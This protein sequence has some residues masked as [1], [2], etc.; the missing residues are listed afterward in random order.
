[1]ANPIAKLE[2]LEKEFEKESHTVGKGSIDVQPSVA[3]SKPQK[4]CT[5]ADQL[6]K[7]RERKMNALLNTIEPLQV[8]LEPEKSHSKI[9][10]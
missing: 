10:S 2:E 6:R 7:R 8:G 4:K 9:P 3:P 1:M 5:K